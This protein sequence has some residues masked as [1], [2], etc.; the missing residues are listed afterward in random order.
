MSLKNIRIG[1]PTNIEGLIYAKQDIITDYYGTGGTGSI[2]TGGVYA[3]GQVS[4][5]GKT[6]VNYVRPRPP[7]LSGGT[8]I[9]VLCWDGG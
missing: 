4:I 2:I 9:R 8:G 7:G 5:N 6:T 3:R 1:K